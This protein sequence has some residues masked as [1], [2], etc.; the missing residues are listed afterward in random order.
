[1]KKYWKYI[2]EQHAGAF[3]T[4]DAFLQAKTFMHG[5]SKAGMLD[6]YVQ[7]CSER[8]NFA[9]PSMSVGVV[10]AANKTTFTTIYEGF[11]DTL[12]T[13]V[14]NTVMQCA[15]RFNYPTVIEDAGAAD[16]GADGGD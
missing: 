16:G 15:L 14:L 5:M 2:Q 13:S 11:V 7:T 8:C 9:H 4:F 10:L 3:K 1:M 6:Q 12:P